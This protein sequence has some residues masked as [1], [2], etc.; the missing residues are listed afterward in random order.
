MG[1]GPKSPL[2][3]TM[4]TTQ[5]IRSAVFPILLGDSYFTTN[6]IRAMLQV[7]GSYYPT[8]ALSVYIPDFSLQLQARGIHVDN[9]EKSALHQV[10]SAVKKVKEVYPDIAIYCSYSYL[11]C[12][13]LTLSSLYCARLADLLKRYETNMAMTKDLNA[14][15]PAGTT[16]MNAACALAYELNYLA[17]IDSIYLS[18]LEQGYN[19]LDIVSHKENS[20]LQSLITGCYDDYRRRYQII[21]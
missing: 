16:G 21:Q 2:T 4:Q 6:K 12:T 10:K 15:I 8:Q 3:L 1:Q 9:A 7:L 13:D 17:A 19:W 14:C 18:K 20:V 5:K 11:N